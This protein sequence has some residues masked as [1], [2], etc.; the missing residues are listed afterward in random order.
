MDNKKAH[1]KY[2]IKIITAVLRH[3]RVLTVTELTPLTELRF[4]W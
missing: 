2:N 1:L 3:N 4:Y